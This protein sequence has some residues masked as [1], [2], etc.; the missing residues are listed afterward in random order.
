MFTAACGS[1]NP[2]SCRTEP[3]GIE[4]AGPGARSLDGRR[5]GERYGQWRGQAGLQASVRLLGAGLAGVTVGVEGTDL[6]TRTGSNGAFELRGVP[7]GRVRLRFQ[8]S[9]ASGALE[10]DDVSETEEI[11]LTVVVSGSTVELE[12]QERVTGSQA[13]LEGK[14]LNVNYG[15]RT[16]AVGTT[17]VHGSRRYSHHRTAIGRWNCEDVIVGARIH[18]KGSRAGDTDHGHQHHG[19]ADGTRT[20]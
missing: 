9:G 16:L 4:R 18:V 3:V 1:D 17:T 11:E 10:L 5:H 14:V 20:A 12:S 8:G 15:A 19:A 7:S 13:Q 6:S 2:L